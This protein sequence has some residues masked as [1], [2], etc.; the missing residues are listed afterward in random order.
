MGFSL[1]KR[2][3]EPLLADTGLVHFPEMVPSRQVK[4]DHYY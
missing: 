1:L 4:Q 3:I 2:E